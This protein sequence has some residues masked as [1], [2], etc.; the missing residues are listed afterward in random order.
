[1]WPA[2]RVWWRETPPREQRRG[3]GPGAQPPE[4]CWSLS[5]FTSTSTSTNYPEEQSGTVA[6][7]GRRFNRVFTDSYNKFSRLTLKKCE[8]KN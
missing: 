3:R 1:M 7:V 6:L 8:N 5:A 4:I 2:T